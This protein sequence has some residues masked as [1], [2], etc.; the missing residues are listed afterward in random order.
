MAERAAEN[1][2]TP[3]F[4]SSVGMRCPLGLSAL[5]AAMLLRARRGEPRATRFLDKRNRFIGVSMAPGL[6]GDLHGYDRMLAL[7][8]PAL[9]AA[10]PADTASAS[11]PLLLAVPEKGRPDDDARFDGAIVQALAEASGVAVD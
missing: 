8:A 1:T 7:A 6:R 2:P 3:T 9:R 5:H 10:V 4:V 11:W